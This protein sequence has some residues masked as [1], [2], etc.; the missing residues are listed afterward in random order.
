MGQ[1]WKSGIWVMIKDRARREL[2]K[3][4]PCENGNG[5][6][7]HRNEAG[8]HRERRDKESEKKWGE[9]GRSSQEGREMEAPGQAEQHDN[10]RQA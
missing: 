5:G 8:S 2:G 1:H 6:K 4:G 9:M 10:H 7:G 3:P